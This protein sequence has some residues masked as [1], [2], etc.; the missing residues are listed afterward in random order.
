MFLLIVAY[1]YT[2]TLIAAC[3]RVSSF[4]CEIAIRWQKAEQF[5]SSNVK[6]GYNY[7][8]LKFV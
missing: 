6:V 2:H 1:Y 8:S 5:W 3:A 4:Q 7:A